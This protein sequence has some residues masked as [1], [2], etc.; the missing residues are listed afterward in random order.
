MKS[1]HRGRFGSSDP[2]AGW[3]GAGGDEPPIHRLGITMHCLCY[4][5][6]FGDERGT[7]TEAGTLWIRK[8]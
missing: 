4:D 5:S 8:T 1:H 2:P 7:R 3:D 6:L